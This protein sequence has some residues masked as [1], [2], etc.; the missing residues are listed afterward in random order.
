MSATPSVTISSP[1]TRVR[2]FFDQTSDE[3]FIVLA[4]TLSSRAPGEVSQLSVRTFPHEDQFLERL[5][6][7]DLPAEDISLL[8]GTVIRSVDPNSRSRDWMEVTLTE[9]QIAALRLDGERLTPPTESAERSA[10]ALADGTA[11]DFADNS[12]Q[13]YQFLMRSPT[14]FAMLSGPKHQFT[15]IN[16]PYVDLIGRS[17]P[18]EVLMK[19]IR[20][21]LPELEGQPFFQWLDEVYEKGV[22]HIGREQVAHMRRLRGPGF[23]DRYFDFV[24]YPVRN[25]K[26]TVYGVMIQAADVT[27]RVRA[28]AVSEHREE[29]LFRQWAELDSIYRMAPVGMALLDAKSLRLLRINP[30]QAEMMGAPVAELLGK[31]ALDLEFIPSALGE[32]FK[33]V[34]LGETVRNAIVEKAFVAAAPGHR[35]W[36]V[37]I[38]PFL[39][40]SGEAVAYTTISLEVPDEP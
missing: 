38:S 19:P 17:S 14:P 27:E 26:G 37:N 6:A 15:F 34:E 18:R 20:E 24:Y 10:S 7:A 2:L 12:S 13:F 32:L 16:Q 22:Q 36:L 25:S 35:T 4:E 8:A 40:A 28:E 30:K 21:V 31:R 9:E 39:G 29:T 1:A 23:E 5:V 11:F 3:Q 33:R